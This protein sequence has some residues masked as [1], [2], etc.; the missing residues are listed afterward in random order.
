MGDAL[1]AQPFR[2][3]AKPA[4]AADLGEKDVEDAI[5]RASP[6]RD[7]PRTCIGQGHTDQLS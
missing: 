7:Q 6:R 3:D 4:I 1:P 2:G 5:V